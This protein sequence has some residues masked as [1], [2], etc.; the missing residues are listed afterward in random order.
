MFFVVKLA[1]EEINDKYVFLNAE[2]IENDNFI[3]HLQVLSSLNTTRLNQLN[4]SNLLKMR[5]KRSEQVN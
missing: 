1:T 3:R 4:A 5:V 2:M